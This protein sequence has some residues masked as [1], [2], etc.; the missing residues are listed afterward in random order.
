[1]SRSLIAA[2]LLWLVSFTP[3]CMHAAGQDTPVTVAASP[4]AGGHVHPS[5]CRAKD[6]TLV[7]VYKGPQVLMR[8]RSTDGGKTWEQPE[9]IATTAKRPD[10]IRATKTFEVY[11]GTAD[12]L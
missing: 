12:A 5:I 10:V 7:V 6:G 1:M 9:A 2:G 4:K 11:P 8:A 3:W